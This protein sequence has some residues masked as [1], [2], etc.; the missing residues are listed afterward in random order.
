M[1]NNEPDAN[2]A[3][4]EHQANRLD[5]YGPWAVITGASDGIGRAIATE[6]AAEGFSL[7][8]VARRKAILS[9]F[10]EE[11]GAQ[12][13]TETRIID[14][15]LGSN[16][17]TRSVEAKTKDLDV[18]LLVAAAGFGTSGPFVEGDVDTEL[19]MIAVNCG[20][21]AALVHVFARRLVERGRGGIV[22]MSSLVAFQGVPRATNYSATK[23]YVQSF[24]EGLAVELSPYGVDVVASAPGP[25]RSGFDKRAGMTLS[26]AQTPEEVAKGTL[27]AL[28]R[29]VT[30]R[31]GFLAWALETSLALLP[32]RGRT[33]MMT[34]VMAGMTGG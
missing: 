29:R 20:A 6:L 21:I 25:V 7:V 33:W 16:E 11:L 22:L 32:R 19:D 1:L 23:A 13:G 3:S 12:Y 27:R 4:P 14:A 5:R 31:P 30:V 10:A 9:E 18:G 17:G 24:A 28:G 8:L 34:R 15:D 26:M 2:R